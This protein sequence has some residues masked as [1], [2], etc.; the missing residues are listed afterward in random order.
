MPFTLVSPAFS[1]GAKIPNRYARDGE[2]LSPPLEWKEPPAGTKSFVLVV[3]DP[4]VPS[5]A[6]RHWAVHGIP[7]DCQLLPEGT[8]ADLDKLSHAVNDF[9]NPHYDGPQP[10]KGDGLHHYHFCLAALDTEA[11][12]LPAKARVGE[13][14]DVAKPHILAIAELVGTYEKA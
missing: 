6:F 14:W 13:V 10:P 5:G 2:N 7:A 12:D 9:G 11:L 3:E 8:A 4:D 1:D